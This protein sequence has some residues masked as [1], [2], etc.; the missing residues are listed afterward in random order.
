M[1]RSSAKQVL[2]FV[3]YE[4]LTLTML[5]QAQTHV[6]VVAVLSDPFRGMGARPSQ[7]TP[8]GLD[9]YMI[10]HQRLAV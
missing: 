3:V 2:W 1:E 5:S 9:P 10:L 6:V 4:F 7:G 8:Q